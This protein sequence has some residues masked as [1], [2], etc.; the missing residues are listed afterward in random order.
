MTLLFETHLK[1][2]HSQKGF[3][4][5]LHAHYYLTNLTYKKINHTLVLQNKMISQHNVMLQTILTQQQ[6]VSTIMEEQGCLL[7]TLKQ[8][9][10][11]LIGCNHCRPGPSHSSCSHATQELTVYP[12]ES[13]ERNPEQCAS[14]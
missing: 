8:Q 11:A 4:T 3:V 7:Y 5:V 9:V 13:L 1:G 12:P 10:T 6:T 14:F 2:L